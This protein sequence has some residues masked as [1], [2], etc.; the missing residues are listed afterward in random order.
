MDYVTRTLDGLRRS[1]PGQGEFYQA[2]EEVLE[3]LAPVLDADR[4]Y[5]DEAVVERLLEPERQIFFRIAWLDDQG[6][7][8]VNKGYRVQFS[9]TLGPYK[10]GLRFH[11][12]V[13]AGIIKFLGFEQIFKNA[14]T[15]LPLGG[16]KGG[17]DFDPKGCSQGEIMRFCQ[18]FMTELHR[19]I[20]ATID[21]PAGDIGV[22]QREIGYLYGQYRR[23]NGRFE[24]V[25]TGKAAGWGG[26]LG[27]RE[28][29]GYGCVYFAENM[30]AERGDTLAGKRCLVSGAG[31]VALYTLEKL[32]QLG[33]RP[34]SCSD[35]SGTLIHRA[36]LDVALLKDIKERRRLP[37]RDYLD[38]HTDATFIPVADYTAGR[39]PVWHEPAELAFPCATQNE[40]TGVD[41][42]ALVANGVV[43]VCEGA[44]MPSTREAVSCFLRAGIDYGPG[45]AANAG[46][47]AVSQLE[48]QQNA[49][50]ARWPA[51]KVDQTLR[52]IMRDIHRRASATA[53]EFGAPGNLVLGANVA[54]FRRVADAMIE[55]GVF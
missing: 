29:T 34:I 1:S 14:L 28:A 37:L 11:P 21:V 35:S 24:G 39:S 32:T 45:K 51:E 17:S 30:L 47:V 48:M 10:G 54:G 19:H 46:G 22:G 40:L 15:G 43:G 25:L 6:R 18:A 33:A 20:G 12:S 16:A 53:E 38:C 8:R 3:V 4:R 23:L 31:N 36:G 2:V 5:Q 44:N 26:S 42:E 41:A 7:V 52:A 50:M 9:S 27:R 49:A 55:Q 13:N